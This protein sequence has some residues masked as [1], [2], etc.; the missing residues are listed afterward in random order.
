M[1]LFSS[2]RN[3]GRNRFLIGY[4]GNI[5]VEEFAKV[6]SQSPGQVPTEAEI[7][8]IIN[9]VDL[10]GDGTINFNG[11][12]AC[13]SAPIPGDTEKVLDHHLLILH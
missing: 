9:E 7:Q 3:V 12:G 8:Q 10:D 13:T 5:S 11:K 1:L 6:M 4:L 2:P